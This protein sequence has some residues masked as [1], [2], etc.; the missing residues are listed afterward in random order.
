M[1]DDDLKNYLT[2]IMEAMK[3]HLNVST[4]ELEQLIKSTISEIYQIG[5]AEGRDFASAED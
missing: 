3:D 2:R 4:I 5:F 1:T